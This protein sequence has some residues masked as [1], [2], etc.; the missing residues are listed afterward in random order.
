MLLCA[1]VFIF[2]LLLTYSIILKDT[3]KNVQEAL[4]VRA[5]TQKP[6]SP[7]TAKWINKLRYTIY[8]SQCTYVF[9]M[10][11]FPI[12][13]FLGHVV[14][15]CSGFRI[16]CQRVSKSGCS[17]LHFIQQYMSFIFSSSL[18]TLIIS[19]LVILSVLVGIPLYFCFSLMTNHL[20]QCLVYSSINF[21]KKGGN[22]HTHT[23]LSH[24]RQHSVFVLHITFFTYIIYPGDPHVI[25]YIK[26]VL[27]SFYFC[28]VFNCVNVPQFL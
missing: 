26:T 25:Y 17:N 2:S 4:F 9:L 1:E 21:C 23:P 5:K 27:I 10:G 13:E 22:I 11:T 8:A 6:F 16:Y 7:S 28:I 24:K 19:V 15:V 18:P 20:Y 3:Y 14:C 12:V